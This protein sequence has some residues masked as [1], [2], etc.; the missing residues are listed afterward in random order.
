MTIP[1]HPFLTASILLAMARLAV[2]ATPHEIAA[3]VGDL[4]SDRFAV[5]EAAS[6]KLARIGSPALAAL[7]EARANPD[8]EIRFRAER[9]QNLIGK[10]DLERRLAAFAAGIAADESALPAWKR[11]S[12]GYGDSESSRRLFIELQ[13]A[14]A[15]LLAALER[16]PRSAVEL[17][18]QR[19]QERAGGGRRNN[20]ASTS[21]GEIAAY[22]FVAAE[23]DVPVSANSQNLLLGLYD[24]A[25]RREPLPA[26]DAGITRQMLGRFISRCEGAAAYAAFQLAVEQNL[27]EGLAPALHLVNQGNQANPQAI[28]MALECIA[29]FGD[30]S[31]IPA[32][33]GQLKNETSTGTFQGTV[34]RDGQ[35]VRLTRERKVCDVALGCLV[36]LTGQKLADYFGETVPVR[37]TASRYRFNLPEIGFESGDAGDAPRA[38]ALQKWVEYRA[39]RKEA[40]D[41]LPAV[42]GKEQPQDQ[43]GE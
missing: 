22:L 3:L 14:D 16:D 13:R 28:W 33:E 2:G 8:R 7:E 37:A 25:T 29:K 39:Q 42:A 34:I 6:D 30:A 27:K 32:V 9:I 24:Q 43:P 5:R 31:H 21:A 4:G 26:I 19:L 23:S 20:S 38:A 1:R 35:T 15:E 17:L 40:G 10:N 41:A 11:F 36:H 12:E 18:G